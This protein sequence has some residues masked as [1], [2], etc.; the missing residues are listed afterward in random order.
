MKSAQRPS[1]VRGDRA[2]IAKY[3]G[4][5]AKGQSRGTTKAQIQALRPLRLKHR[6][7]LFCKGDDF[8]RRFPEALSCS[9]GGIYY[10][11]FAFVRLA[12]GKHVVVTTRGETQ[13]KI[14]SLKE[15]SKF[16]EWLIGEH[17]K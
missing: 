5:V 9:A 14:I 17:R 6:A 8:C 10:C 1:S 7:D 12:D 11:D 2:S 4:T 15:P 16:E 3:D 13:Y